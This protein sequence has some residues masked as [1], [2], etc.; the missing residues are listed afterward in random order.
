MTQILYAPNGEPIAGSLDTI[1]VM[2]RIAAAA[3][4]PDSGGIYD[5]DYAGGSKEF[6]ETIT[7][8]CDERGARLFLTEDGRQWPEDALMLGDPDNPPSPWAWEGSKHNALK[9]VDKMGAV[10]DLVW[11]NETF[12][13][14]LKAKLEAGE[15]P[16]SHILYL[17]AEVTG[18]LRHLDSFIL[19]CRGQ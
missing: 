12:W 3:L 7:H 16:R 17:V 18:R 1:Q 19:K 10:F 9:F 15:D 2:T 5:I 6:P 11:S 14:E 8:K 13:D 4:L